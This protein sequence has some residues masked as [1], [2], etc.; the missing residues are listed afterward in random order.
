MEYPSVWYKVPGG[1]LGMMSSCRR[2]ECYG[3]SAVYLCAES[4]QQVKMVSSDVAALADI[5]T[6]QCC[7]GDGGMAGHEYHMNNPE[8]GPPFSVWVGYGNCH[9]D[10]STP[11]S[12]YLP[13]AGNND[14]C[15][16]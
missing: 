11:P 8:F 13:G 1:I 12:T 2:V 4:E 10:W 16:D 15:R 6:K 5:I 7:K 14:K 9:V 3:T